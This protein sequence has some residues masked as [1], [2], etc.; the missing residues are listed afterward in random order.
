M[1]FN[2]AIACLRDVTSK[3]GPYPPDG[4]AEDASHASPALS[5]GIAV[6]SCSA[7]DVRLDGSVAAHVA[8]VP[9][10][11]LQQKGGVA[12][13]FDVSA[14]DASHASPAVFDEKAT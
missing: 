5:D 8:P 2:S 7:S 12:D 9:F 13:I 6:E 11:G 4:T 10:D 1:S 14:E 3:G